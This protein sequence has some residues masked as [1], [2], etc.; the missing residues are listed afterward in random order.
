MKFI[1]CRVSL[2]NEEIYEM[3]R[4]IPEDIVNFI[5]EHISWIS[6]FLG[7]TQPFWDISD[8][9]MPCVTPEDIVNF[10]FGDF[11][12]QKLNKS[13]KFLE[14]KSLQYLQG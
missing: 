7:E 2:R 4:V 6:S 8:R 9:E 1:K 12:H 14:N 13:R 11:V 5:F 3:S 10:Y